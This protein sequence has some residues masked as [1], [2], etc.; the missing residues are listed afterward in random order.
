[1]YY[2]NYICE[3]YNCYIYIHF[4][5]VMRSVNVFGFFKFLLVCVVVEVKMGD[6][7]GDMCFN[8]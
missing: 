1:M 4:F 3:I 8:A 7:F 5:F 2:N 6:I